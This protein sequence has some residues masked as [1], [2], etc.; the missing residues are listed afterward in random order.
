M[1]QLTRLEAEHLKIVLSEAAVSSE[2]AVTLEFEED[3]AHAVEIVDG[4]LAQDDIQFEQR[5]LDE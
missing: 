5:L 2:Y 3:L 4:I 1:L